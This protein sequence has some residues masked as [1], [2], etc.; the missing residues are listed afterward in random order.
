MFTVINVNTH[1][2]KLMYYKPNAELFHI[3]RLLTILDIE[4]IGE[5]DI[6]Q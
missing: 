6:K 3:S 1:M 4:S 5:I 2:L